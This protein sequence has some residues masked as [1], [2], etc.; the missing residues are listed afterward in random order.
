MFLWRYAI[1]RIRNR[2]GRGCIGLWGCSRKD[3][4][5]KKYN[6]GISGEILKFG[7]VSFNVT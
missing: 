3:F 4:L 1:L 5:A 6:W 7:G 2:I